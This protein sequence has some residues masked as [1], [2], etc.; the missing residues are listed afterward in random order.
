MMG[1]AMFV[2]T[3]RGGTGVWLFNFHTLKLR[4]LNLVDGFL[5]NPYSKMMLAIFIRRK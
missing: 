2:L 3:L 1:L 5:V 4:V